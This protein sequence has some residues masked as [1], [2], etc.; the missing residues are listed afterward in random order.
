[1]VARNNA[2]KITSIT[3]CLLT[4]TKEF[5]EGRVTL[6]QIAESFEKKKKTTNNSTKKQSKLV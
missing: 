1:M 5:R 2:V 3:F 4:L 6:E